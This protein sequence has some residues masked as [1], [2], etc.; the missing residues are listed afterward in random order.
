MRGRAVFQAMVAPLGVPLVLLFATP[1][2]NRGQQRPSVA[3]LLQQFES[4]TVF[5]RQIEVAKAIVAANDISVLPKLESWLTHEDRHLRG[6]A[7][8]IYGRLGDPH[9]FDVIV[10]ILGDHSERPEAQGI[11]GGRWS[12]QGQIRA[13]RYYAAHLLGDLKDPRAVPILVPLLKDTEVNYIVPWSLGQIGDRSAVQ[14]LIRALRDQNPSMRVLAIY[15]LVELK[16][17]EA[18]PSLRQLLGD[19][20]RSNF[21]KLE[22]VDEAAQAAIAK[23][24]SETAR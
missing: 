17:T 13:D 3:E 7:A 9:G 18:L 10:A 2:V 19:N 4:T 15:A 23:L 6:N 22:S 5:W 1:C 11:P 14:P 20:E 24:Q 12:L 21:G 16:A 8:F